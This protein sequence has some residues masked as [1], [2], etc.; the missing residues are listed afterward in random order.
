MFVL[1][2]ILRDYGC[3]D[4]QKPKI[5]NSSILIRNCQFVLYY[6]PYAFS[7]FHLEAVVIDST[8]GFPEDGHILMNRGLS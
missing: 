1:F 2:Y 8:R 7:I 5:S 6:L 3:D 4:E